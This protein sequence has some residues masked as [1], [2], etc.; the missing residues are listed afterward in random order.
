MNNG[1]V[2]YYIDVRLLFKKHNDLIQIEKERQ[3]PKI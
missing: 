2:P 1:I 3:H